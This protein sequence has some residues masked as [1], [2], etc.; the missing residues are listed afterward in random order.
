[1]T[2]S[3][4]PRFR[5][6]RRGFVGGAAA[7]AAGVAFGG[8]TLVRGVRPASAQ[9]G[10]TIVIG[11][12][13]EAQ[14]INPYLT[15][16]T[17]G[18]W[19][20]KMLFDE[21]VRANPATYL[22]EPGLAASWTIDGLKF[23]F[24]LQPNAKFSD[25]SDVTAAD[26]AFTIKGYIAPTTTSPRQDKFLSIAGAQEYADGTAQD[27]SGIKVID[28]K[29]LEIT[30]AKPDAPFLF[31][32]RWV[33]VLPTALL[34]GKSLTDDP[35]FQNP[36]GA[37]PYVFKSWDTGG[38]FVV[39]PNPHYWQASKPALTTVT[40]RVIADANSLV[41]ALQA[42]DI[43]ASNYPAPTA[44]DQLEQN[45]DLQVLVPPF[46]YPD[47]I[48]FNCTHEWLSKKEVRKAIAMAID[49]EQFAADSLLGLGKPGIGP[50]AP[51]NW[52]FDKE[53]QP[54]PY[55]V[56]GAKALLAQVGM[57]EGTKIRMMVNQGNV[58]REDWLTFTQQAVK[59]I[60]IEI[61]PEVIEWATLVNRVTVDK[62]FDAVGV[63]FAGVT[64]EPSE[65]YDQL[66][67][68]AAGNYQGYSNPELDALLEQAREELDQNAAKAIYQQIQAIYM[69][70]VPMFS[71]WYRPFLHVTK[72]TF[73]NFTDSAAY[74]LFH[75]LEDWTVTA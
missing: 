27:V 34:E 30:L 9:D 28:P 67:T 35:F 12:L 52:A 20:V 8:A 61:V 6:S 55:D 60:G 50:I 7:S 39:T 36:V 72:K 3:S 45:E 5:I 73:G 57:P 46:T 44:K 38:D 24:T 47:G 49:T 14:T 71:A 48:Y 13:G 62:D 42:G 10:G 68:G 58:L 40:H 23:T 2:R 64:A 56:E 63:P 41:L 25:G 19:R 70:D 65:L 43:D 51:D 16:E 59:E 22:A 32:L 18:Q 4:I 37:G 11:T 69:D 29:T 66:H 21:F 33:S 74:G 15:S 75:T 31:N 1:M 26:V 53:L 17:E 54:I